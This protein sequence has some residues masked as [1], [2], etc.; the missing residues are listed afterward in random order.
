[1]AQD[2]KKKERQIERWRRKKG[3][4]VKWATWFGCICRIIKHDRTQSPLFLF[5]L[6]LYSHLQARVACWRGDTGEYEDT[7]HGKQSG[8][9]CER[10]PRAM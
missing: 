8:R 3:V 6:S 5:Y 1:M 2:K 9:S 4:C 7:N 10:A